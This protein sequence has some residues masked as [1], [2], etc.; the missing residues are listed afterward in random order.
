MHH[1]TPHITALDADLL[2]TGDA[3][4]IRAAAQVLCWQ[5]LDSAASRDYQ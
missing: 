2:A 5:P 3:L 4:Q 1:G